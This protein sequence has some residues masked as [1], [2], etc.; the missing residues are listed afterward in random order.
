V[1]GRQRAPDPSTPGQTRGE[2][3]AVLGCCRQGKVL[4]KALQV[5]RRA[6]RYPRAIC[7]ST[8]AASAP[9]W[10]ELGQGTIILLASQ[11]RA[12]TLTRSP[13]TLAE[14]PPP[15]MMTN[16]VDCDLPASGIGQAVRLAVKP[17]T[18][19]RRFADGC[20]PA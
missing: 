13:S 4:I 6:T 12:E 9:E 17:R 1:D 8:E 5:G 10:L 16:I 15:T 20:A 3:E 18:A 11:S 14:G 2:D 7:P 19:G